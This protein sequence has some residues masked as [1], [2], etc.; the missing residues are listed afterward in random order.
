MRLDVYLYKYGFSGSR[1]KSQDMI[2]GGL[3]Y[4]NDKQVFKN[5]YEI[6][7]A[8]DVVKIKSGITPYVSRGGL[9]LEAAL[10]KFKIDVTD[11]IAADIG[12]STGGFTDCLL[13]NG[14]RKVYA[15][16]C[17]RGQLHES[18]RANDKVICIENCNARY[19]DADI[20]NESCD[21]A[22][23]DLSFISQALVYP[24]LINIL[25]PEGV[26]ISLIKPQFETKPENIGKNGIVKNTALHIEVINKIIIN[27]LKYDLFCRGIIKSPIKGGEGNTEYL[28]LFIFR[29]KNPDT[30]PI[31]DID[32]RRI[33][34]IVYND[35][36]Y[37]GNFQQ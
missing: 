13:R 34:G 29:V 23:M 17:G 35:E 20:I 2:S 7:T 3:I 30:K 26:L 28:A 12:A 1:Q 24:A 33:K 9:K 5:S 8:N 14:I 21:I 4:V 6:D 31:D 36:E 22:V 37:I 18:L 11:M 16:D 32:Y 15:V 27:A 19:I 25:K 10:K